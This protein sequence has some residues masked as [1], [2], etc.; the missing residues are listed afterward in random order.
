MQSVRFNCKTFLHLIVQP[1][2]HH[3]GPLN[4]LIAN[5]S[6]PPFRPHRAFDQPVGNVIVNRANMLGMSRGTGKYREFVR[7]DRPNTHTTP[8]LRP[9][10]SNFDGDCSTL[11]AFRPMR[12]ARV[13]LP[14]TNS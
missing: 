6:W 2:E 7:L 5:D 14:D 9:L 3:P 13:S 1:E 4:D 8:F 12:P 11:V 10:I